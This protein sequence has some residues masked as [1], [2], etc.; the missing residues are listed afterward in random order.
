MGAPGS[1]FQSP[2]THRHPTDEGKQVS[3][4][5]QRD[6][7][8]RDG[9]REKDGDAPARKGHRLPER[10]LRQLSQDQGEDGGTIG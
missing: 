1:S 2:Q 6:E 4:S 9:P 3:E 5:G 8:E 10:I 7:E